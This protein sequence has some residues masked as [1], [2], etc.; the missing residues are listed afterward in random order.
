MSNEVERVLNAKK[1]SPFL[2]PKQAAFYVGLAADTL[3]K[4][5]IRGDGPKF[6]KH[7]RFVRYH[8]DD[9]DAWSAGRTKTSTSD[10]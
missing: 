9:L 3:Q 2:S 10:A 8:L 6:R 7:G 1:V 5:R 4:M